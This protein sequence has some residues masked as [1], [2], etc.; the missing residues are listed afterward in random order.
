M[1]SWSNELDTQGLNARDQCWWP[2]TPTEYLVCQESG[3]K[4]VLQQAFQI[5]DQKKLIIQHPFP[6]RV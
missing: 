3:S 4:M 5:V 6:S 2:D 1:N